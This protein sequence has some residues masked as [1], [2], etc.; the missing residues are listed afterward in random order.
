MLEDNKIW[1]SW[2]LQY[3][4]FQ[5]TTTNSDLWK[6]DVSQIKLFYESEFVLLVD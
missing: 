5:M 4:Q 6:I 3:L 2:R 1:N